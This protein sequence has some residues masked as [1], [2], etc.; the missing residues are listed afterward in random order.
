MAFVESEEKKMARL[1]F[2][3]SGEKKGEARSGNVRELTPIHHPLKIGR[4]K[5]PSIGEGSNFGRKIEKNWKMEDW[6]GIIIGNII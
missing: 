2:S 4:R 6:K 1:Y 3:V 5:A